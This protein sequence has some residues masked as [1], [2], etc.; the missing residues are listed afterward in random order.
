[1]I[2]LSACNPSAV[3]PASDPINIPRLDPRD[4]AGC[5]DPGVNANAIVATTENRAWG[6]CYK[7]KHGNVV[8]QYNDV[9][10]TLAGK[11]K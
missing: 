5:K 8:A 1:M 11:A 2:C 6:A 3:A 4:E 7:Q 9:R 10:A